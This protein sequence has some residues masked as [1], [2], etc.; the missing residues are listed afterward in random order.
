MTPGNDGRAFQ[1]DGIRV[2]KKDDHSLLKRNV[3][4]GA[5]SNGFDVQGRAT[6]LTRNRAVGNG[7]LGIRAVKGV[8]DGGGNRASGNGDERQCVNVRC[9]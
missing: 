3:V 7:D 4:K 5:G 1:A 8:I 9:H 2:E 6:K